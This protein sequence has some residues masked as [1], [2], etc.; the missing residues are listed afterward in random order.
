[1]MRNTVAED[2]KNM[3]SDNCYDCK[4]SAVFFLTYVTVFSIASIYGKAY[5]KDIHQLNIVNCM[6]YSS[7]Y[8]YYI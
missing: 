8:T 6:L 5:V 7:L 2:F 4:I 1:M 3:S